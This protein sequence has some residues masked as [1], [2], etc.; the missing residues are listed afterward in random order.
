MLIMLKGASQVEV[1]KVFRDAN[2]LSAFVSDI[3]ASRA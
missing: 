2:Y 3:F 1:S